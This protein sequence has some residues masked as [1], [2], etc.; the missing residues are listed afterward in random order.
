MVVATIL[1]L[2]A[3]LIK[4]NEKNGNNSLLLLLQQISI[5]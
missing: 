3:P 2:G 5:V 4:L 1:L